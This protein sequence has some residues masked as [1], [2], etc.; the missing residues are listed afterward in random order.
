MV[1]RFV[2]CSILDRTPALFIQSTTLLPFTEEYRET[3][4]GA[5]TRQN[6]S[7]TLAV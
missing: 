7:W 1:V 5:T 2:V 6:R 3:L 4:A